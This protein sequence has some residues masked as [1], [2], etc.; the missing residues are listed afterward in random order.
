MARKPPKAIVGYLDA[1]E[2]V[3]KV[4]PKRGSPAQHEWSRIDPVID[5]W[6]ANRQLVLEDTFVES[7]RRWLGKSAPHKRTVLNRIQKR[8]QRAK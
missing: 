6:N 7:V 5:W 1:K 3:D 4:P 8:R 2:N